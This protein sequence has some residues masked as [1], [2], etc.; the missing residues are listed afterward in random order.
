MDLG[1]YI[2]VAIVVS[3]FWIPVGRDAHAQEPRFKTF[4]VEHG[5]SQSAVYDMMRDR[6]GFLWLAT[7]DG[8]NRYDGYQFEVFS[9]E[10]SDSTSLSA[11]WISSLF[12]DTSGRIWVGTHGG[13]LNL[14]DKQT[15]TFRAFRSEATNAGSLPDESGSIPDDIVT[16][17]AQDGSGSI[18]IATYGGLARLKESNGPEISFDVYTEDPDRGAWLQANRVLSLAVDGSGRLWAG[19]DLGGLHIYNEDD[20]TFSIVDI[21]GSDVDRSRKI[22]L[23]LC[24]D[25]DGS[26]WVGTGGAGIF[27]VNAEGEVTGQWLPEN[28]NSELALRISSISR[29][30][31]GFL[32]V[33][34]DGAGLGK[35]IP[36]SRTYRLAINRP[37]D[38]QSLPNNTVNVTMTDD[39][40]Y[41]WVGTT[42][43][44]IAR[45][46]VVDQISSTTRPQI[47]SN[48]VMALYESES[49]SIWVGTDSGGLEHIADD[50]SVDRFTAPRLTH[51]RVH[52]IHRGSNN[53]LWISTAGGLNRIDLNSKRIQTWTPELDNPA[54]L[55]DARIFAVSEGVFSDYVWIA[56]WGGLHRMTQDGQEI[57]QIR[58]EPGDETSLSNNRVISVLEDSRGRVWAGTFG[59]GLN[60]MDPGFEG[61]AHFQLQENEPSSISGNIIASIFESADS[62]IWIGT[63]A[64]LNR[65][66]EQT[67][68]FERITVADGLPNNT[69]YGILEDDDHNLWLSTNAGLAAYEPSTGSVRTFTVADGLQSNEFNQGAFFRAPDGAM[70]FG[71]INGFN[72]FYPEQLR[73]LGRTAP[74]LTALST[75]R[76]SWPSTSLA[77]L[78]EVELRPG[79]G[80]LNVEFT[81]LDWRNPEGSSFEVKLEGVDEEWQQ[82]SGAQRF[83][84]WSRLPSGEFDL[85]IRTLGSDGTVSAS[86]K[87]LSVRVIPPVT[88][89]LWFKLLI[90]M[91][92]LAGI[93]GSGYAWHLSRLVMIER[94]QREQQEVH[95]R[96]ME[97][98]ENERLHMAQDLHDG[99]VQ[100]LYGIRYKIQS[101]KDSE[102]DNMVLGVITQLRQICGELRPPVLAP[103]G[104]AKTIR[105][106]ADTFAEK[107]GAPALSVDLDSDGQSI[108]EDVRLAL[109]RVY[110]ES[111]NNVYKHAE[112]SQVNV[113][114]K[115]NSASVELSVEDNGKG[116]NLPDS[117]IEL[118]RRDHFG[119][120]GLSERVDALGAHLDV[121]SSPGNGTRIRVLVEDVLVKTESES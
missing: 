31:R 10:P 63:E 9:H 65:Y 90:G 48:H 117:W 105:A 106:H 83:V 121:T 51:N 67:Q 56:T 22:I 66:D 92:I 50:G 100:D 8:L 95:Q 99:A 114:L 20:N 102:T 38:G 35:M 47:S 70:L 98:R 27:H 40:G 23:A 34:T 82:R 61:F 16:D 29:D 19:T 14:F 79:Y 78:S 49:G 110:Q 6:D 58:N 46:F 68:F 11:D 44:G 43:G 107:D 112:A 45:E 109:F 60:R 62:T 3:L 101:T 76:T 24:P 59:S 41:F 88:A 12:E 116:F 39:A 2:V 73:S 87:L 93:V 36:D 26:M 96:L 71:G 42:G 81:T 113:G 74:A 97:G 94:K 37:A 86:E 21:P 75:S 5:L 115:L 52:G 77:G 108:P 69:I 119:L 30:G 72:R 25:E 64:G 54:T 80:T 89:R 13:G 18:W 120:M 1:R 55:F 15:A 104:L 28:D 85:Q 84:S 53:T 4:S 7:Q 33:G 91:L 17:I 32:R 57:L 118:G 111:M 103:F